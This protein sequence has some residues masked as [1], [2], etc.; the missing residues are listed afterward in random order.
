MFSY[1]TPSKNSLERKVAGNRKKWKGR[2]QN[3]YS[4]SPDIS[5]LIDTL[6]DE[7]RA[8]RSEEEREERGKASRENITIFLIALTLIAV[9]W[10]V[11][12]MIKVYD[13]I[14]I[15]ATAA[16]SQAWNARTQAEAAKIQADA[17]ASSVLIA[18]DEFAAT[19]R[20]WV[21]PT[22]V[23]MNAI[24]GKSKRIEITIEYQNT[25]REPA[26]NFVHTLE[27]SAPAGKD[28]FPPIANGNDAVVRGYAWKVACDPSKEITGP[29]V[30]PTSGVNVYRAY[31]TLD[32]KLV[33]GDVISGNN[34]IMFQGCFAY[35]SPVTGEIHNSLFCYYYKSG[36]TKITNLDI[37]PSGHHA[38]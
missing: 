20:A 2:K 24:P 26:M 8:N 9:S 29:V 3:P 31:D 30:F 19:Q 28:F 23:S 25:G 7:G 38:N 14:S 10:Q 6:I 37:C 34:I 5:A 27:Q 13:P 4:P 16:I 35:K 21:G 1:K 22:N 32:Q 11:H 18:R 33:N 36:V 12:E 17:A 15:Q